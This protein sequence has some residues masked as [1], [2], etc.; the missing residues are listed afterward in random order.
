MLCVPCSVFCTVVLRML[1]PLLL[2]CA[3]KPACGVPGSLELLELQLDAAGVAARAAGMWQAA[4]DTCV[5][6][7]EV[8]LA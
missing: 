6:P 1:S 8:L 5:Q 2:V 4:G 7:A 3:C